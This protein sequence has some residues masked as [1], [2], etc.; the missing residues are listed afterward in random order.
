LTSAALVAAE[1]NAFTTTNAIA[2]DGLVADVL[3]HNPELNFYRAEIAAA[4]GERRLAGTLANPE[5]STQLGRKTVRGGGT[6]DEGVAWSVSVQQSFEWP[7]RLPLRK[8]IANHQ[9][10][11]AELGYGQFKAALAGKART[12]AYNLFAAQ[13]KAVVAREVADRFQAL[14]EVLVQRDPAGLTPVL[15]TRII[16]STEVTLH[17]KASDESLERQSALLEL[18]QLRGQPWDQSLRITESDLAFTSPPEMDALIAAAR[19]NNFDLQMRQAEL[20]QQGFK[21]SLAKSERYPALSAGPYFSQ[22]RAG[23]RENIIGVGVSIPLPLWN[24]NKGNIETARARELQAQT[25]LYVTQREIE[26]K[27][28]EQMLRYQVKLSEMSRWRPDSVEQF[29][30]AATLADRHYRLGAVPIATYV[31]LQKQYL[32]AVEALLDT[33]RDALDAGQQLQ[34]LTGIDFGQ[35]KTAAPAETRKD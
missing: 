26:R 20:E 16:E 29:R 33:K 14:R 23:D 9:I 5:V 22:E 4:K 10:K 17:R 19:T 31:E 34:V 8:A 32:E 25:S 2:M 35:F 11:L 12:L 24:R 6:S 15:E 1:T 18:N 30:E 7:G 21:V 28:A 13:K 27:V 3:A